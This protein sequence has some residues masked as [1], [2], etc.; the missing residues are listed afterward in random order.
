MSGVCEQVES[1]LQE[2]EEVIYWMEL[3]RES[4]IVSGERF[5]DVNGEAKELLA[6]LV[7]SVKT[8]KRN[9]EHSARV[10]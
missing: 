1:G 6:I 8:A 5:E 9:A 10:L 2:L 4:D 7:A 3:L